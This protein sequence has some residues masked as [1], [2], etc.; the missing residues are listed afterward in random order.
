MVAE[1]A[2]TCGQLTKFVDTNGRVHAV[3]CG[4]AG[5]TLCYPSLHSLFTEPLPGTEYEGY[6]VGSSEI[7]K[8]LGGSLF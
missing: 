6:T 4:L 3:L 7:L 2:F 1:L 8:S 5:F